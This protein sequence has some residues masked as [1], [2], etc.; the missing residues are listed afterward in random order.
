MF[1]AEMKRN[2]HK[3][4]ERGWD[5]I[6]V[7]CWPSCLNPEMP[8][9]ISPQNGPF[10]FVLLQSLYF[11]GVNEFHASRQHKLFSPFLQF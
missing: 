9:R 2:E 11:S 1:S 6:R 5:E 8:M 10:L 7:A 4:N 3:R